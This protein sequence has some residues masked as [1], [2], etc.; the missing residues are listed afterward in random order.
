MVEIVRGEEYKERGSKFYGL[1]ARIDSVRQFNRFLEQVKKEYKKACHY[2]Y[3]YRV[4][5]LVAGEQESFFADTVYKEKS[6]NDGEPSGVGAALLNLLKAGGHSNTAVIVV[7]YYG[8]TMLGVGN[9]IRAYS[10]A[11]KSSLV[12]LNI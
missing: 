5:E 3:A 6:S 10:V 9:L 12:A 4:D 1:V 11:A 7:R 8:G 2:C